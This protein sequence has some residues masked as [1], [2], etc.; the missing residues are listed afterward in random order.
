MRFRS[1]SFR[2]A[3]LFAKFLDKHNV[4]AKFLCAVTARGYLE[5]P[6]PLPNL[7]VRASASAACHE[8]RSAR[9][10]WSRSGG[11]LT[12][13]VYQPAHQNLL[14][15]ILCKSFLPAGKFTLQ[16]YGSIK[17]IFLLN[18]FQILSQSMKSL[19]YLPTI[20]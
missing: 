18:H 7:L 14:R 17:Q 16:T 6:S 4:Y 8:V 20:R 10:T 19:G 15:T 2:V 1:D 9:K 5:T 13:L 11:S 12:L 3:I